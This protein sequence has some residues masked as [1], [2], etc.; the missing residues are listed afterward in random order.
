MDF[1]LVSLYGNSNF[2]K[3]IELLSQSS[4]GCPVPAKDAYVAIKRALNNLPA[5]SDKHTR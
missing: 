2:I 4:I 1:I 5:A 3:M